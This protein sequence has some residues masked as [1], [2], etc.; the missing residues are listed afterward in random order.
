MELVVEG[1]V[2]VEDRMVVKDGAG[3]VRFGT[4]TTFELDAT[5]LRVE[6]VLVESHWTRQSG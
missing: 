6:G 1:G 2:V 5:D 3:G 4:L